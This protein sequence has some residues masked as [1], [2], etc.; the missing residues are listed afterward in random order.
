MSARRIYAS[1]LGIGVGIYLVNHLMPSADTEIA[2]SSAKV[3]QDQMTSLTT[4][5]PG[6]A[7]GT[8]TTVGL[9]GTTTIVITGDTAELKTPHDCTGTFR[10]S[11]LS[12]TCPDGNKDRESG[13]AL[14]GEDGTT[15]SVIWGSGREDNLTKS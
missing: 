8:W 5:A 10:N 1:V 9:D 14:V 2:D 6:R 12:L 3:R 7:D 13:M 11:L 4:T 15:L